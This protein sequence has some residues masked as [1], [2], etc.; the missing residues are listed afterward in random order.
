MRLLGPFTQLVPMD[1]LP[2]RGPVMD[3]ALRVIEQ[4]G[5]VESQG[6]ILAVGAYPALRSEYGKATPVPHSEGGVAI[7]GFV[8]SHTHICFAGSRAADFARRN[9]GLSYQEIAKQGGGIWNTV[10]ATRE[11]STQGLAEL[12]TQRARKMTRRGCTTIEV[13]SGYGLSVE[14]ELRILQAIGHAQKES[15]ADLIPTC[16]AA[17][18][19]PKDFQ[20]EPQEYLEHLLA[21]LLPKVK[22]QGLADRVD[23]FIEEGAF[24]SAISLDYLQR[25]KAMGFALTVHAD[26]FSVG[27]SKVAIECG[28]L[29]ADHLEVSSS[30]ELNALAKSEVVCTALPGASLGLG[31]AFTPGRALLDA[32]ACLAIASDYNPGSAP[33]GDL[34]TQAAIYGS[35]QKLRN[36]EVLAGITVR[37]ALALGL[38]DRGELAPSKRADLA[39]FDTQDHREILYHQGQL[40]P[41]QVWV[42]GQPAMT[43]A[44]H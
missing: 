28:A 29:S 20:G 15:L 10:Q 39:V 37:G 22:A 3:D 41:S 18:I 30:D 4:G 11:A 43:E 5:I 13:K 6:Q 31:C 2:P 42:Q 24:G 32:G 12:T 25:A 14:H 27:G 1:G 38:H 26:Q 40:G 9:A 23:I 34:L 7:P 33:M 17:H 35:V 44:K 21:E 16:L 36:A 8:D 19:C